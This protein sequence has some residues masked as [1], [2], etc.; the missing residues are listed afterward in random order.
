MYIPLWTEITKAVSGF[1]ERRQENK[2]I[3]IQG[4]INRIQTAQDQAAEWERIQA[5]NARF[6]WRDDY[7][8]IILSIPLI[9]CFIPFMVPYVEQGFAALESMPDY[10]QYW[11]AVAIL[12]SFGVRAVRR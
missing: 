11:V 3:K 2:R 10:Y 5:E 7:F 6:S 9:M 1:F 8:S 12:S 4:Q